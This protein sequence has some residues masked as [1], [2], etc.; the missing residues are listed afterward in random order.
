MLLVR[1]RLVSGILGANASKQ[2]APFILLLVPD[3]C[4]D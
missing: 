1:F 4:P 3:Q 2:G